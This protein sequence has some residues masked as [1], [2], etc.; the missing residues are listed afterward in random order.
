[1]CSYKRQIQV[2][3]LSFVLS[4]PILLFCCILT[5]KLEKKEPGK[6]DTEFIFSSGWKRC[7]NN[8]RVPRLLLSLMHCVFVSVQTNRENEKVLRPYINEL[9][10]KCI[11]NAQRVCFFGTNSRILGVV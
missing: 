8:W 7:K 10:S 5:E 3:A 2:V 4:S 1:M 9:V 6:A 11:H